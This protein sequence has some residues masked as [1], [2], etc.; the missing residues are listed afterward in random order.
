MCFDFEEE[1][2]D[3]Y[4][5]E[6]MEPV[7]DCTDGFGEVPDGSRGVLVRMDGH[8][9]DVSDEMPIEEIRN[10]EYHMNTTRYV[11]NCMPVRSGIKGTI[12][13]EGGDDEIFYFIYSD[14][15]NGQEVEV[16]V[17]EFT[18]EIVAG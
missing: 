17:K 8:C 1:L 9:V 15:F 14:R 5:E 10:L 16:M 3:K 12:R 13:P 4:L 11:A 2:V 7:V 6:G 18:H